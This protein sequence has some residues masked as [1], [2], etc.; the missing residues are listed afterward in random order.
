M[1]SFPA[2]YYIAALLER[3]IRALVYVGATDYI[4]NWVRL[5]ASPLGYVPLYPRERMVTQLTMD[6]CVADGQRGDDARARVDAQGRV[7]PRAAARVD[8][9]GEPDCR[10]DEERRGPDVRDHRRGRTHG[11]PAPCAR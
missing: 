5:P 11:A 4:C 6:P 7:P 1:F 9:Q 2:H 3:G 10:P 8:D